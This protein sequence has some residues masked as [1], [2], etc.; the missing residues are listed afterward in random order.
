MRRLDE[1]VANF[2][3]RQERWPAE[4]PRNASRGQRYEPSGASK[5]RSGRN[6][7]ASSPQYFSVVARTGQPSSEIS[8]DGG[9][10]TTATERDVVD[11]D[12]GPLG[13]EDVGSGSTVVQ[14]GGGDDRVG[15]GEFWD[16]DGGGEEAEGLVED[17]VH[18]SLWEAGCQRCSSRCSKR[19]SPTRFAKS[20]YTCYETCQR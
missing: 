1:P 11:I 17:G 8:Q 18:S 3:P 10:R 14:R 4:N 9:R 15:N 12:L 19:F 20:A 5:K 16:H 6:T 2:C 7:S 13:N